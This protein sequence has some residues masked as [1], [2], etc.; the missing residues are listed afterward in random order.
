[1]C[2]H[3][4]MFGMIDIFIHLS[5]SDFKST[6]LD[7]KQWVLPIQRPA[8]DF[9][10]HPKSCIETNLNFDVISWIIKFFHI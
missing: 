8:Q 1:M 4:I 7:C 5:M 10:A 3:K 9:D 6:W 2:I